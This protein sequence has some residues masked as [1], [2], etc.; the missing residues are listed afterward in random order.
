[1]VK[2]RKVIQYRWVGLTVPLLIKLGSTSNSVSA[3]LILSAFAGK[4]R[5]L[6]FEFLNWKKK[7]SFLHVKSDFLRLVLYHMQISRGDSDIF[8]FFKKMITKSESAYLGFWPRFRLDL[9]LEHRPRY[10]GCNQKY[11]WLEQRQT[12]G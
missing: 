1:M 9:D 6:I 10:H 7:A 12:I 2:K 5:L 8:N 4:V 3:H 11:T